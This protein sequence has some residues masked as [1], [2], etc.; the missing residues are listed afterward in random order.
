MTPGDAIEFWHN[1]RCSKSRAALALLQDR[2][3]PVRL[4]RY[5]EDGPTHAEIEAALV[6]LGNAP[7]LTLIRRGEALFAELGL[8]GADDARLVEAMATHPRLIERPLALHGGRAVI[9]RP[10]ERVLDLL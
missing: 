8:D 1:P 5:L 6:A 2:G 4:R 7:A 3:A 10:P 9:G